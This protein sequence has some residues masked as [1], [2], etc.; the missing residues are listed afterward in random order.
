MQLRRYL[1]LGNLRHSAWLSH[2]SDLISK[3]IK[4]L[5]D[6]F[7]LISRRGERREEKREIYT[8]SMDLKKG[9][10]VNLEAP[11]LR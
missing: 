3:S 11:L 10:A 7:C 8:I 6:F 1:W 2:I 5:R 4:L 9:G